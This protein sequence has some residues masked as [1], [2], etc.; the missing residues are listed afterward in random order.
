MRTWCIACSAY[1]LNM[2]D[3]INHL[4]GEPMFARFAGT[5]T[6]AMLDS[7]FY[8]RIDKAHGRAL[9]ALDSQDQA[10]CAQDAHIATED[11]DTPACAGPSTQPAINEETASDGDIVDPDPTDEVAT[12]DG[13]TLTLLFA[14]FIDG[15][16]LHG[17]GRAT[18]TVVGLKC[19]DLPGFLC[20]TD[21]ACFP[22]AYIGG[23]KEPTC[24]TQI[25]HIILKQFKDHE[26]STDTDAEGDA[27]AYFNLH[28]VHCMLGGMY[29]RCALS[30]S[31]AFTGNIRVKGTPIRVWDSHRNSWRYV[32]PILVFAF[33]DTPARRRWA[34]TTGHTGKSG[35]DKCGIRGFRL[36]PS[37]IELNWTAF[38]GYSSPCPVLLFDA[39]SKVCSPG[40][41]WVVVMLLWFSYLCVPIRGP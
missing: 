23:V 38:M 10:A 11:A 9:S 19:I 16:Q 30:A 20:N 36:L 18:T 31:A 29:H 2:K 27:L 7:P 3:V 15:V 4:F 26:V 21:L 33:A 1:V 22:L 39:E 41:S 5:R 40:L 13:E 14:L 28:V 37:G 32:Y 24:L 6:H 35:C 34:L 12:G 17:H 25:T 8:Q